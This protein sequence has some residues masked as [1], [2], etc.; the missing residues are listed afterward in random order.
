MFH[1][2]FLSGLFTSGNKVCSLRT[3]VKSRDQNASCFGDSV[4][5]CHPSLI[6]IPLL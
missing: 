2:L 4:T 6:C 3:S 1:L 5:P